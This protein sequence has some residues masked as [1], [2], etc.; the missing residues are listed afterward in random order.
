MAKWCN[1]FNCWCSD[2][3]EIIRDDECPINDD[4]DDC[5]YEESIEVRN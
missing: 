5:E 2:I 1:M 4:C 3:D